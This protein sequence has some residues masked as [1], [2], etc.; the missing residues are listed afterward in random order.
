MVETSAEYKNAVAS[1]APQRAWFTFE[2]GMVFTNDDIILE[3]GVHFSE[4]LNS[5]ADIIMG[6]CP[7]A[8]LSFSLFNPRG[9]LSDFE[10]G[11]FKANIGVQIASQSDFTSFRSGNWY[12]DL[13]RDQFSYRPP[14]KP[15]VG[16]YN[17]MISTMLNNSIFVKDDEIYSM[18]GQAV[19]KWV[20]D[21]DTGRTNLVNVTDE[22]PMAMISLLRY[23]R[24]DHV[25]VFDE[26]KIVKEFNRN[27]LNTWQN[28][29]LG[30]FIAD[31]P[32]VIN[33]KVVNVKCYDQM[34]LL[35]KPLKIPSTWY[36]DKTVKQLYERICMDCNVEYRIP[37]QFINGDYVFSKMPSDFKT[38][39]YR[40]VLSWIA[41]ANCSYARFD[42]DGVLEFCWFNQTDVVLDEENSE[43]IEE[44]WYETPVIEQ[45]LVRDSGVTKETQIGANDGDS[46]YVIENNPILRG[47]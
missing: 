30:V 39:T 46:V 34:K 19:M 4:T 26:G 23:W 15:G 22:V 9:I 10:W 3:N 41:E 6:Q 35:D 45:L 37:E 28:V 21:P 33:N 25:Y 42:R 2:N 40:D 31:K 1:H 5:G 7:S 16:I 11:K 17:Y 27:K 13:G 12:F 18:Q 8:T 29:S 43:E 32:N 24:Q 36:K 20:G 38:V 47:G 14:F 44:Y